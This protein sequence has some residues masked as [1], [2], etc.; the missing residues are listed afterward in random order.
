MFSCLSAKLPETTVSSPMSPAASQPDSSA[1][2][3]HV[4]TSAHPDRSELRGR[5]PEPGTV[6]P[7]SVTSPH[8]R[9][10]TTPSTTKDDFD[11][12]DFTVV[13][14]LESEPIRGD[15]LPQQLPPLP[16]SRNQLSRLDTPQPDGSEEPVFADLG[17]NVG[18]G[19]EVK[20]ESILT[21][22]QAGESTTP[23]P[24][25]VEPEAGQQPAVVFK[26]EVRQ[27]PTMELELKPN[28]EA[29]LSGDSSDQPLHILVVNVLRGNQSGESA[30]ACRM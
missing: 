16:T 26:D 11:I 7:L 12:L 17:S 3:L 24:K 30:Q 23:S 1:S 5:T 25:T 8:I 10:M 28:G 9:D 13:S 29:L 22:R 27:G 19:G 21:P 18:V 14:Q 6:S 4:L 20:P 15:S 2:G